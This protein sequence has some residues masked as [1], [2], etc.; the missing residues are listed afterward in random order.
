MR[1][2]GKNIISFSN[3]KTFNENEQNEM[4]TIVRIEYSSK[5]ELESDDHH[6]YFIG[7]KDYFNTLNG[8]NI[9][10]I[11]IVRDIRDLTNNLE[12]K[13]FNVIITRG[14]RG[15]YVYYKNGYVESCGAYKDVWDDEIY[16]YSDQKGVDIRFKKE[17]FHLNDVKQVADLNKEL[18]ELYGTVITLNNM[19]K[20]QEKVEKNTLVKKKKQTS[21][22]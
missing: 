8:D 3:S 11:N 10:I 2:N 6:K 5:T 13:K 16:V 20:P 14:E 9:N 4:G 17:G 7:L 19:I 15:E 1:D 12:E 21:K 18:S 22:N